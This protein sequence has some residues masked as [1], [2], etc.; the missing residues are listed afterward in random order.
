MRLMFHEPRFLTSATEPSQYPH[1]HLPEIAIIGRSNV[2]KSSLLNHLFRHRGLAKTSRVPGKTRLINFFCIDNQLIFVD[3]PGYGFAKKQDEGWGSMIETYLTQR[4][5]LR[6]ILFLLD[7]RHEP[8]ELDKQMAAWLQHLHFRTIV[9]LTKV[10]KLTKSER[11]R[12]PGMIL[13]IFGEQLPPY[14][15]YS[16]THNEGRN[17]LIALIGKN[18]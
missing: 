3:L 15:E 12:H 16:S 2:G 7:S 9:V 14:V 10:D 1:T 4:E 6:L 8:S 13:K 11:T 18:L 17:E 5:H